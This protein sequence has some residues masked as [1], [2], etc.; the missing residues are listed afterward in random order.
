M[1]YLVCIPIPRGSH[2][3][4]TYLQL[5]KADRAGAV[6]I[7][8]NKGLRVLQGILLAKVHCLGW[9]C[10]CY[11]SL[12]PSRFE[13]WWVE[14]AVCW[15][16]FPPGDML[17]TGYQA[18]THHQVALMSGH[19]WKSKPTTPWCHK[20]VI[21]SMAT[22]GWVSVLSRALLFPPCLE[23][24]NHP[25]CLHRQKPR[26]AWPLARNIIKFF[27]EWPAH[28]NFSIGQESLRG[29]KTSSFLPSSRPNGAQF[30]SRMMFNAWR[31]VIKCYSK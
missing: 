12:F 17:G 22:L 18:H 19:L 24:E 25:I 9:A 11:C 2:V 21:A 13:S 8:Q 26:P 1:Q 20:F 4:P 27:P 31:K 29:Y 15:R 3:Q 28:I 16:M 14:R 10:C 5:Y 6:F 30:E 23:E 7:L